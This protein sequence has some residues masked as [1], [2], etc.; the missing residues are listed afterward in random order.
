M[1]WL[2]TGREG[3]S[4]QVGSFRVGFLEEVASGL[5]LEG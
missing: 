5:G 3:G 1:S 4:Q 2:Q